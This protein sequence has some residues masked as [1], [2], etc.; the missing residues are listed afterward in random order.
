MAEL[1]NELID[2]PLELGP[3]NGLHRL[4]AM[5]VL[6][7]ADEQLHQL[8]EK[9]R[10][11]MLAHMKAVSNLVVASQHEEGYWN[12]SWPR[13]AKAFD[14]VK[15]PSSDPAKPNKAG[16]TAEAPKKIETPLHDKLLVTG[17]HLEWLALAPEE[18]QPPRETIVRAGQWLAKTLVEMDQKE[19]TAAYGPYSH[20]ARALCLWRGV[21]PIDAWKK[22]FVSKN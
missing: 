12:R 16:E 11:K 20:A 1:V 5:V 14:I 9:T 19:L 15:Q 21:E 13:G 22:G 4:E 18:V 8:P 3:C 2:H 6:Y 10:Q 17:H 7:R